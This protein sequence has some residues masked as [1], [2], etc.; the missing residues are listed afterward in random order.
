MSSAPEMICRQ[1]LPS[2]MLHRSAKPWKSKGVY[3]I[4]ICNTKLEV[5]LTSDNKRGLN[6]GA[7][8]IESQAAIKR[9][10]LDLYILTRKDV[11]TVSLSK[12]LFT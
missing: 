4:I 8:A 3:C 7:D 6:Y 1:A 9:N 5:M 11:S 12:K 10:D 2:E